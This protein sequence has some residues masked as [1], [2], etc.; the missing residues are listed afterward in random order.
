MKLPNGYGSVY[1]LP[2]NRRR[3][4]AVRI[5]VSRR[6]DSQGKH[7]LKYQYLG[8]Y[9]TY[10]EGLNALVHFHEATSAST[11]FQSS[12]TFAEV[13]ENWSK[14]HFP[15]VSDSNIR[16]YKAAFSLCTNLQSMPFAGIRKVPIA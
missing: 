1:K 2:G 6:T 13:F 5:T 14:E 9:P 12:M 10:A 15:K 16:G 4:W 7:H 8:Y 11:P 3:P